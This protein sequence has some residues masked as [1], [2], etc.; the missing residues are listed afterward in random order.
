MRPTLKDIMFILTV[1][2]VLSG[3]AG[4][5]AN[6]PPEAIEVL[7]EMVP[8]SFH[9]KVQDTATRRYLTATN[10]DTLPPDRRLEVILLR[11]LEMAPAEKELP[12]VFDRLWEKH[13]EIREVLRRPDRAEG[14]MRPLVEIYYLLSAVPGS[15]WQD[16]TAEQ[17]YQHT[18]RHLEPTELSGYA[19]HF[20]TLALL[21][22]R[23]FDAALPFLLR[24]EHYTNAQ[25]Y[26]RDLTFAF[27]CAMAG[28]ENRL[29]CRLMTVICQKAAKESVE[30]P[31]EELKIAIIALKKAG[32]IELIRE[33]LVPVVRENPRLQDYSFVELLREPDDAAPKKWQIKGY[34][35]GDGKEDYQAPGSPP[36]MRGTS[37]SRS[38]TKE[39]KLR[40]EVQVIE[41]GRQSSHID[42]ALSGIAQNL[43]ETLTFSSFSLID[44]KILHLKI[45][46][47]GTMSLPGNQFLRIIPRSLT[48]DIARI[49]IAIMEGHREVFHTFIETVDTGVTVIGGPRADDSLILL[50]IATFILR[51][52]RCWKHPCIAKM[53]LEKKQFDSLSDRKR[54]KIQQK[55]V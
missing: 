14:Y 39:E 50:R 27:T 18:L 42:P 29:A 43:Q 28:G 55:G 1:A 47:K 17:L 35:G 13:E 4:L 6:K 9:F 34:I 23:K 52:S 49:E 41:A 16:E 30:L 20:Y 25:V 45:G 38:A 22:N 15:H 7:P 36:D 37:A 8:E 32:K 5:Q 12:K 54:L 48:P 40:I 31:D 51:V 21:K 46:E 3:C 24:L 26:V 33:A 44:R 2:L 11:E 19:L 53:K 10:P